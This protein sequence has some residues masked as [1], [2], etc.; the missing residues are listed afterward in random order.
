MTV[1][2]DFVGMLRNVAA[3]GD[4]I[5]ADEVPEDSAYPN[6]SYQVTGEDEPVDDG[7]LREV[8]IQVNLHHKTAELVD[9]LRDAIYSAIIRQS[10]GSIE[11]IY[12]EGGTTGIG[13]RRDSSRRTMDVRL[14][15]RY[16]DN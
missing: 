3:L 13:A 1:R 6:V 7:G 12:P 16:K 11:V 8:F 15:E 4:R 5:Y 9:D 14:W 10:E 2:S